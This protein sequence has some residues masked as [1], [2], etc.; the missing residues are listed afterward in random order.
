MRN[1]DVVIVDQNGRPIGVQRSGRSIN[2][3]GNGVR[4]D[5]RDDIR[6]NGGRGI[7][8][9]RG[10]RSVGR[11]EIIR[12]MLRLMDEVRTVNR[13]LDNI[14]GARRSD[15]I[16]LNDAQRDLLRVDDDFKRAIRR[17]AN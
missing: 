9:G 4:G 2:R 12:M 16:G 14:E 11:N 8:G 13:Q 15:N 17:I 3:I 6:I 5:I 10:V 7:D 1:D